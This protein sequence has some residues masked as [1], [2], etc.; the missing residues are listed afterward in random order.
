MSGASTDIRF[1]KAVAAMA[2]HVWRRRLSARMCVVLVEWAFKGTSWIQK[3][4]LLL[5]FVVAVASRGLVDVLLWGQAGSTIV[6]A[7]TTAS[8]QC[9]RVCWWVSLLM[10]Q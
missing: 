3:G 6:N 9:E 2:T 4:A 1:L 7:I 8:I 10:S 5:V